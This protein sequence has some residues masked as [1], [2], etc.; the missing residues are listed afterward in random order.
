MPDQAV[1]EPSTKFL[2]LSFCFPEKKRF[3]GSKL[4]APSKEKHPSEGIRSLLYKVLKA[5]STCRVF[6]N[7][8][9]IV[10]GEWSLLVGEPF[11]E[12]PAKLCYID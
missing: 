3:P 8:R 9:P 6:L 5:C 11:S 2:F 10:N 7:A 12:V 1:N 4:H